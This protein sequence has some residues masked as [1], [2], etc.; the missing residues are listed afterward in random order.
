MGEPISD[1]TVEQSTKSDRDACHALC[2]NREACIAL[3]RLSSTVL[4]NCFLV[5]LDIVFTYKL[6]HRQNDTLQTR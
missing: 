3:L 1:N 4:T 2:R 5:I 6:C